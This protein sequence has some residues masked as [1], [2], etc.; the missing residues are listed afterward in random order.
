MVRPL[1]HMI[2]SH[3]DKIN[4]W[5][6][7]LKILG[8]KPIV[9]ILET[10]TEDNLN[11]REKAWI[12]KTSAGGCYLL[13]V[14]HNQVDKIIAQK[15]YNFVD[16]DIMMIA[17][18]IKKSRN[19]QN[20]TQEALCK[21]AKISRPT[22]ISMEKGNKKAIFDNIKKVLFILGYEIMIRKMP[23]DGKPT[24]IIT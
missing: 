13:N 10:C 2:D 9:K 17:E 6:S 15:E 21:I 24:S 1:Q 7:Q 16:T 14:T 4:E 3:S 11:E 8:S 20:L 23:N 12:K 5:V 18:T 22:L 19:E